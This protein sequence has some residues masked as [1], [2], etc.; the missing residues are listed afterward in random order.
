[1]KKL[2]TIGALA[3]CGYY[4]FNLISYYRGATSKSKQAPE[5]SAWPALGKVV[6]SHNGVPIYSNGEEVYKSHGKH[7]AKDGFYYGRK[8]QC[9]EYIKRY[10]YDR[11]Q[12]KMPDPWG[13]AKDYFDHTLAQG[14]LN[15]A[16]NLYQY[17]NH[18]YVPP[19]PDDLLVWGGKYGHVAIVSEV[20]DD[21][22]VIVQQN[23]KHQPVASIKL[24]KTSQNTYDL[25]AP[26]DSN[27]PL[28]WLRIHP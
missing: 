13:H 27:K 23:I 20:H 6:H 25:G 1:M 8:W 17:R 7:Y 19:K 3:A 15:P 4:C 10:F 26:D 24:T 14:Q 16:R 2:L 28:G 22:I 11:H 12:H 5:N 21:H 9:V 18:G